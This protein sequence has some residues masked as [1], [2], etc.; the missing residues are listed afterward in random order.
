MQ[1]S[2]TRLVLRTVAGFALF[3]AFC[4]YVP[5]AAQVDIPARASLVTIEQIGSGNHTR[6]VQSA[7][8]PD[9]NN[10]ARVFVNGSH[11]GTGTIQ[12]RTIKG[13]LALPVR[14]NNGNSNGR[15][16]GHTYDGTDQAEGGHANHGNGHGYGHTKHSFQAAPDLVAPDLPSG[17]IRQNGYRNFALVKISNL[18]SLVAEDNDFHI[19]QYGAFNNGTQLILGASNSAA[20]LQGT[21]AAP[22]NGNYAVQVQ[23]GA[24]NYSYAAQNGD[25]N[26]VK[27]VQV[28]SASALFSAFLIN[29]PEAA[30]AQDILLD[31]GR[32][33]SSL[34]E[35]N[36]DDNFA[37]TI[38]AGSGNQIGLR[39]S[40]SS[41]AS[42]TQIG[43]GHSVAVEQMA[44]I[45]GVTPIVIV[46]SR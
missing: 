22:V 37:L 3:T 40:G 39:Q 27:Q 6:V 28:G 8:A 24:G 16:V 46:Q 38:Q 14:N 20:L 12:G 17:V 19:S 9:A 23:L 35:Q 34:V 11:N 45:N 15:G 13:M 29:N 4:S 33:N 21:E 30:L 10:R 32:G 7:T 18:G 5:A 26:V 41:L 36:G 25:G 44:G 2:D 43:D 1:E 42:I 31:G